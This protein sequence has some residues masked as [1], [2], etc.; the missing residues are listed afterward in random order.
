MLAC[1]RDGSPAGRLRYERRPPTVT[2]KILPNSSSGT[3]A[4]GKDRKGRTRDPG[5][6]VSAQP[7]PF[8]AELQ[9]HDYA[10]LKRLIVQQGLLDKQLGYYV[11]N[12][13][14]RLTLLAASLA[15]L[16]VVDNFWLQLC[17]AAFLA[18]AFTQIGYLGHDAGH[19]QIFNGA[20]RN[21]LFGLMPSLLLGLSRSWWIDTHNQHH[22]NPNDLD[23]DPHTALPILAF[24]EEQARSKRGLLRF[25]VRYQS[26]YFFPILLLEGIGVRT[27]SVQY[28][29]RAEARHRVVE[30]S[31]MVLHVA[32]YLGLVFYAL[33]VGQA[34]LF[35]LV[36]QALFGLYTGSVFAPN[37]KGMPIVDSDS[38]L[39]FVRR[40]VLTSRDVKAHPLTD[41]WYGGL[42]YQIE[43]HLFPSMPRNNLKKAQTI[44]RAF[45]EERSIPYRESSALQSNREILQYL[46]QVSAP[47]REARA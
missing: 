19:R 23:L 31:L 40:Q 16:L 20:G 34:L 8:Q 2:E 17:N 7:A 28:L 45:C 13:V 44:V 18:F 21:D 43:H 10:D 35:I 47:L 1:P 25:L 32:L 26:L 9:Q 22:T 4:L 33:S 41:F 38:Q 30:A 15:F 29:L 46:H 6:M 39:D 37:H 3:V 5:D 36:H 14:V 24:S 12:T 11:L 27:A 42:N